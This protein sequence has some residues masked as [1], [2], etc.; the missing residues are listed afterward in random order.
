MSSKCLENVLLSFVYHFPPSPLSGAPGD[1]SSSFPPSIKAFHHRVKAHTLAD[2]RFFGRLVGGGRDERYDSWNH[3]KKV[4][5][6]SFSFSNMFLLSFWFLAHELHIFDSFP[7]VIFVSQRLEGRGTVNTTVGEPGA[8]MTF[9]SKQ[10]K[11]TNL[12][13]REKLFFKSILGRPEAEG[14]A[15]LAYRVISATLTMLFETGRVKRKNLS[16]VPKFVPVSYSIATLWEQLV[17]TAVYSREWISLLKK[18]R[19]NFNAFSGIS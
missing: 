15:L 8:K 2:G 13:T 19:V 3:L 10:A 9:R 4:L 16:T 6:L 1:D 18:A 11:S 7:A 5:A 17:R 12:Q 14:F